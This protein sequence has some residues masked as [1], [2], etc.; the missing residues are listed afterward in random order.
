MINQSSVNLL[1]LVPTP[2][3]KVASTRGGEYHGACPWCGGNDRFI[4]QPAQGSWWCRQ[5]GRGGDAIAFVRDYHNKTFAEACEYLRLQPESPATHSTS[6][7]SLKALPDARPDIDYTHW[8]TRARAFVDYANQ[9]LTEHPQAMAYLTDQRKL[10]EHLLYVFEWGYNPKPLQDVWGGVRVVLPVGI[11]MPVVD[12]FGGNIQ[13]IKIRPDEG[14]P[15]KYIQVAGSIPF[16][17]GAHRI[18]L[19]SVVVLTEGEIDA[20][21][22]YATLGLQNVVAVATG[23]TT[24]CRYAKWLAKLGMAR[25]VFV[26]FDADSAGEDASR[27]WMKH[28]PNAIRIIPERHD[29][30]EMLVHGDNIRQWLTQAWKGQS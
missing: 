10:P 12:T 14:K 15:S 9:Q 29:I 13:R 25:K 26:A 30:N 11:V 16:L 24:H 7:P 1:E 22:L 27:W 8:R 4:V 19:N 20:L 6:P 5:C 28:L 3:K 17:F 2:M 18:Q 21:S 23:S